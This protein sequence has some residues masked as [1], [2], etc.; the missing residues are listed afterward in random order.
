MWHGPGRRDELSRPEQ[1]HERGE[2]SVRGEAAEP[3]HSGADSRRWRILGLC[4]AAG[5]MTLLDVSIVNVALPSI[6]RGLDAPPVALSWV[7]SGYALT[8]GLVLIPAGKLGD[9]R[10][11][12]RMFVI[13]LG[14]FTFASVLAGVAMT[15]LWLVVARLLQGVA[16]GMLNPQVLGLIQQH[17]HG[18]ERGRAFGAFG[19]VIG[20]STAV[21]PLLGGL[22]IALAGPAAGWR[23]VFLVNVPIGLVALVMAVRLLPRE[24]ARDRSAGRGADP[25]G[26][27]LLGAGVVC[28]L[29]PLVESGGGGISLLTVVA[30]VLLAL[31]VLW[32]HRY[33]LRGHDP[34]VDLRVFG[35][36]SYS[37]GAALGLL[38]FAG[39]T[40]I[41]FVLA[42][43]FQRGL[44][45]SALQAG[46]ALTPFAVGSAVTSAIGGRVVHRFGRK[47]VLAGLT[48]AL[49]G[50]LVTE[51]LL[52]LHLGALAGVITAGPLL[53]AGLGSGLVI[54]PNQTVTLSEVEV[55]HGGVAAGVQQTGQRIG[56]AIGTAAA[57]GLFFSTLAGSGYAAAISTGLIASVS[58]VAAALVLGV[59]EQVTDRRRGKRAV[60]PG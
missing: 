3:V 10:G 55:A 33:R 18:A 41:F 42:V 15:P 7:V 28:L 45:Y 46:L 11:R 48:A 34:L 54:S 5:F 8:F 2:V 24:S 44:G 30:A 53:L 17:F 25:V 19:A 56:S 1:H 39:F 4:L 58:F 51:V 57:S 38:Y 6:Q 60:R 59:V 29:L 47:L 32:E 23:W 37:F 13:S 40:G 52:G 31:F 35:T 49:V 21:G 9:V 16:G 27:A 12:G 50:L 14:A 43:Y 20:I 26:V 36:G 22:I